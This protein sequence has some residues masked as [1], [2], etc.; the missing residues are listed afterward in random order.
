MAQTAAVSLVAGAARITRA[1]GAARIDDLRPAERTFP[2]NWPMA[3]LDRTGGKL[4][5]GPTLLLNA[6]PGN[7]LLDAARLYD[8][9]VRSWHGRLVFGNDVLLF[10][11]VTITP[12]LIVQAG[13]PASATVAWYA[14]AAAQQYTERR[15][16]AGKRD[17]GECLVL[18]LAT[19]LGGIVH[20]WPPPYRPALAASVYSEWPVG[21][22]E[23]VRVLRPYAGEVSVEDAQGGSYRVTGRQA[24]FY[25]AYWPPQ[26]YSAAIEPPALGS[27]RKGPL[28]HWDLN[29][30]Q[31][32]GAAH[33][34]LRQ[35]VASGAL[36]LALAAGGVAIDMCGFRFE[37]A[38][39]LRLVAD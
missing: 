29:A 4:A 14:G 10:G 3:F 24:A 8:P 23:V 18:G 2:I 7:G 38:E 17:D 16:D 22:D 15:P 20:P 39:E 30:S 6:D 11:P 28:H 27:M 1:G 5:A 35:K 34:E 33:Q 12:M 31:P 37:A 13:L 21:Q 26:V 19:R 25:T 32:A 9:Q 36:A